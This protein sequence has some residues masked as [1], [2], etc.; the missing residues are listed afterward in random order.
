MR[1]ALGNA[2]TRAA[3]PP[4]FSGIASVLRRLGSTPA[5]G[6]IVDLGA[7]SRDDDPCFALFDSGY[8]GLMVDGDEAQ[9]HRMRRRFPQR[10]IAQRTAMLSPTNV[11][12]IL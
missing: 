2:T 6:Y 3:H 1:C 11:A 12:S 4:H 9:K 5:T 7:G 8:A 10:R